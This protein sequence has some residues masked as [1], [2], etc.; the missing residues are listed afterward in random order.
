MKKN[1]KLIKFQP[2]LKHQVLW[3]I[4]NNKQKNFSTLLLYWFWVHSNLTNSCLWASIPKSQFSLRIRNKL[5]RSKEAEIPQTPLQHL[6][7]SFLP[8][9]RQQVPAESEGL[10]QL[11]KENGP[12]KKPNEKRKQKKKTLNRTER[13]ITIQILQRQKRR[14]RKQKSGKTTRL[15]Q[16]KKSYCKLISQDW[17]SIVWQRKELKRGI[18]ISRSKVKLFSTYRAC[19]CKTSNS[20]SQNTT[21]QKDSLWHEENNVNWCGVFDKFADYNKN[22]KH[23]MVAVGCKSRYVRGQPLKSKYATSTAQALKEM[24]TTKQPKSLGR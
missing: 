9:N 21:P 22:I 3:M 23:L 19:I 4:N 5:N 2:V 10:W 24:I 18:K 11:V 14:R 8:K 15:H 17:S 16:L 7:P 6:Q 12:C 13:P 1:L 20:S